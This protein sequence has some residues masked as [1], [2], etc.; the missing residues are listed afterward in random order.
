MRRPTEHTRLRHSAHQSLDSQN[1]KLREVK[2]DFKRNKHLTSSFTITVSC[3]CCASF[4]P[5]TC[6]LIGYQSVPHDSS[7]NACSAFW[8]LIVNTCSVFIISNQDGPDCFQ[9]RSVR[10]KSLLPHLTLQANLVRSSLDPFVWKGEISPKICQFILHRVAPLR[11]RIQ[12]FHARAA[13]C[14]NNE[15]TKPRWCQCVLFCF[16]HQIALAANGARWLSWGFCFC[17]KQKA[18]CSLPVKVCL[19][20][21]H[22]CNVCQTLRIA[23]RICQ[24]QK[25]AENY[26]DGAQ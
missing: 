18:S 26:F 6:F 21:D 23:K 5:L 3:V 13:G 8:F 14:W 24:R 10:V 20:R 16:F 11:G 9:E 1:S 19:C 15:E 25:Q 22:F 7:Q 2:C 17:L 12:V 4:L